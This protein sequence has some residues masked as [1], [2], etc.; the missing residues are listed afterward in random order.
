MQ[1]SLIAS[2]TKDLF[3]CEE[4][5]RIA[6]HYY[7]FAE[8]LKTSI[9]LYRKHLLKLSPFTLSNELFLLFAMWK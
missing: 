8:T 4:W 6:D 9:S 5:Q 2:F 3:L 1:L 7:Q